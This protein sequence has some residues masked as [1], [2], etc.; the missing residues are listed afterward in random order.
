MAACDDHWLL[1]DREA[2][3]KTG[4]GGTG[5]LPDP[6]GTSGKAQGSGGL[7]PESS[8]LAGTQLAWWWGLE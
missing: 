4:E 3:V 6:V 5:R 2:G 7:L 8:G 1:E